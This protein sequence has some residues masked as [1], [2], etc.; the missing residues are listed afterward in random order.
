MRLVTKASTQSA[1]AA[2]DDADE[3]SRARE[4]GNIAAPCPEQHSQTPLEE[5]AHSHQ[6]RLGSG[7]GEETHTAQGSRHSL[8]H[9]ITDKGKMINT[10]RL[11][12][13]PSCTKA[14]AEAIASALLR[15]AQLAGRGKDLACGHARE[16]TRVHTQSKRCALCMHTGTLGADRRALQRRP[17]LQEQPG[18]SPGSRRNHRCISKAADTLLIGSKGRGG[19]KERKEGVGED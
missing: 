18:T 8:H 15:T 6:P 19:E 13:F 2:I 17:P 3:S 16:C 7:R 5:S 14:L 9:A 12:E 10:E 11:A 4:K 1:K